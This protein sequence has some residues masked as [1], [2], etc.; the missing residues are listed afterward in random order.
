MRVS[1]VIPNWNGVDKLK[2]NLPEVLKIKGISEIILVDDGSTDKSVEFVKKEFPEIKLI[3]KEKNSGFSSTVNLG[4]KHTKG[5]FVFLLNTDAVPEKDCLEKAIG[6]FENPKI[7]SVGFNTGGSWSW[8]IFKNGYFWHKKSAEESL[9]A[10]Q[11]LWASGG[12]GIFRKSTWDELGG[13]DQLMDPFYEEDVDLGYRATKR[14]F[15]NIWEPNAKVVHLRESGV[16]KEN[17]PQNFVSKIAQ[18]NQLIFIWKNITDPFLTGQHILALLKTL[19]I[20]PKYWPVFL[21]ALIKLPAILP[22]RQLEKKEAK[23]TDEEIF[24]KFNI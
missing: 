24:K 22:K 2:K 10:H 11:T 7:F 16:I 5:E 13:L 12:S 6:H 9:K 14:G 18:R 23:I 20:H 19:I 15:I 1:I 3:L 17:F 21:N 4:V 8:A